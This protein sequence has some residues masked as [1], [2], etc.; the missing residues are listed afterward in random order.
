MREPTTAVIPNSAELVVQPALSPENLISQAIEKG[1]PVETME[2]LLAMRKELQAEY[3]KAEFDKAMA[4]FQAECPIVTKGKE[5]QDSGGRILYHYAPLEVIISEVKNLIG[6]HGLSYAIKTEI[7]PG[8]VK[9]FCVVK[10]EAGHSE[11]SDMEVPLSTRTGIMSA[12]QQ[13]AATMT[14]AKR[15]AF[16]NAFGIMT[17]DEDTDATMQTVQN[18]DAP[19]TEEQYQEIKSL[20]KKAGYTEDNVKKRCFELYGVSFFSISAL[21]AEGVIAG[22]SKKLI[23]A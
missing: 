12:P 6:K 13:T 11:T 22:L 19:A 21:Q 4:E 8:A 3:A 18:K 17:G 7:K 15:Y 2:R 5:V 20:A 14:F 9:V 10:H 1:L 23:K 16:C